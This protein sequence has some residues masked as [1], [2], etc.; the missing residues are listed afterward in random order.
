MLAVYALIGAEMQAESGRMF[1]KLFTYSQRKRLG[2]VM[3]ELL[4]SA[5]DLKKIGGGRVRKS[6]RLGLRFV[7]VFENRHTYVIHSRRLSAAEPQ[8]EAALSPVRGGAAH[9]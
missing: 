4:N 3:Q 1:V 5:W 8:G 9:L 2:R 6:A 7:S